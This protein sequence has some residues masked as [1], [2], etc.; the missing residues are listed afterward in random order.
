MDPRDTLRPEVLEFTPYSPGLSIDEIRE[1]HGL[2]N[3]IKLAS[4]ENPLGAS[5]LVRRVLARRSESVFRYPQSGNPRLVRAIADFHGVDPARIVP[6]NGSDE[7]IDLMLR[8]K[9]RPGV[10]NVVA[11]QPCFSIYRLQAKLCGVEMRQAPLRQDFSFPFEELL[12]LCDE[13]TALVFVTNPDNP[14]GHA[15]KAAELAYLAK[16]LPPRALLVVDEAYVE[17][18]EPEEEHSVLGRLDSLPNVAVLRTFSKL[19]G[20]AGLR[21]GFGAMPVWL[22]DYLLRVRLPFS[23]NLLAEA[24]GMAALEDNHFRLASLEAV[25]KG[26][27]YLHAEL[28]RL[29]CRPS[30]SMANFIL[31]TPPTDAQG[32]FQ[33]LLARGIII[34]PL[35]SYGMPA[36]LRVSIGSDPENRAFV[37]ALEEVLGNHG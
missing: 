32:V 12:A 36:C 14:S 31:F 26:R 25:R 30:P 15:V 29:G 19:H 10:D 5:P 13:N 7:I 9:A 1:R 22:A 28:E 33:A 37:Q 21:L 11:F 18:A 8:V 16:A 3:V 4:N 23:V 20:L 6:G 17:F 35:A 27:A 34:R 24:A 2:A